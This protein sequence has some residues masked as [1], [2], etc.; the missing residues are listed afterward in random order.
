VSMNISGRQLQEPDFERDVAAALERSAMPASRLVLEITESVLLHDA[1]TALARLLALKRLGIRLALDD[2]GT[3][4]SSLAY[5][6][7]FPID[8]LKMDRS[9]TEGL[10]REAVEPA[11]PRAIVGLG[12]S[13][14]MQTVAEGIEWAAQF[15]RL[16]QLGC[17]IG[18][19]FLFAEPTGAAEFAEL[20]SDQ[21]SG[22]PT[23]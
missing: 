14:G 4:Y 20:L 2:F 6:Q 8:V 10:G 21:D 9:F 3:G 23:W 17:D 19:G 7:R 18:Q 5:L 12:R 1:E 15:S 13:L 11:L 22:M 16:R